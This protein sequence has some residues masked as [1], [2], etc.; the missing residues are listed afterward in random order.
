[1]REVREEARGLKEREA[2]CGGEGHEERVTGG[3][4]HPLEL[5]LAFFSPPRSSPPQSPRLLVEALCSSLLLLVE[6]LCSFLL[7]IRSPLFLS[8]FHS[9][10]SSARLLS[11]LLSLFI[12]LSPSIAN[13]F[14]S[15][16]LNALKLFTLRLFLSSLS[17]KLFLFSLSLFL[18]PH[19]PQ[20]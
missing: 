7:L 15:L 20:H 9:P 4:T 14:I 16:L 3:G 6:A 13:L 1:M 17:I 10:L 19:S 11:R 12:S 5:F 18:S 8:L 2:R